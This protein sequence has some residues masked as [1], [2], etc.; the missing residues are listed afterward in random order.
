MSHPNPSLSYNIGLG[1]VEFNAGRYPQTAKV[2][3]TSLDLA[4]NSPN[5]LRF[6]IA[7]DG[8]VEQIG[9]AQKLG[10]T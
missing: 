6:L 4:E 9:E 10:Q 8:I 2:P 7:V 5:G 3:K 1:N